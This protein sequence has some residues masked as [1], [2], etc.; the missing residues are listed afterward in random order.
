[1][2]DCL[3]TRPLWTGACAHR[4]SMITALAAIG[5]TYWG[6]IHFRGMGHRKWPLEMWFED[7]D[8]HRHTLSTTLRKKC[9]L[10]PAAAQ[11]PRGVTVPSDSAITAALV[12]GCAWQLC[13]LVLR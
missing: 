1:M 2:Q 4:C 7:G 13:Q 8:T 5:P 3:L 10:Q 12:W 11:L 6:S 9:R